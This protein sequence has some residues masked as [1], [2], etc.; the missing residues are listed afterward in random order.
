MF[1][2]DGDSA[3]NENLFGKVHALERER[4]NFEPGVCPAPRL[5]VG[6]WDRMVGTSLM[7]N[8]VP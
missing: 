6:R 3:T 4:I 5:A 8:N 2:K 7:V 1:I